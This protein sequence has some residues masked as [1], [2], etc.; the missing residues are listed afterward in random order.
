MT[1]PRCQPENRPQAK[2]SR[3]GSKCASHSGH[4]HVTQPRETVGVEQRR[5]AESP[6]SVPAGARRPTGASGPAIVG[7]VLQHGGVG[8]KMAPHVRAAPRGPD[9]VLD[10][11]TERRLAM[12]QRHLGVVVLLAALSMLVSVPATGQA[13][14]SEKEARDLG[15]EAYIYGYPLV[16]MEMT[17]AGDDQRGGS[18][19]RPRPDGPVR[20]P[21]R[22]P[23]RLVQRRH[24]AQRRH[25]LL[26][27]VPRRHEGAVRPVPAGRGGSLLP[28]ADALRLDRRVPGPGQAHDRHQAPDLRDHR[29]RLEGDASGRRQG[30]QVSDRNGLDPRPHL[31]H[32]HARGLQGGARAAG[33]VQAGAAVGLRQALHA[34][35]RARSIRAS[36]R[37]PRCASR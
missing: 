36:T 6:R 17:Q 11:Q 16:T 24:R 29:S 10:I 18:G 20:Q 5:G 13:A 7:E 33:P 34:A 3:R 9:P 4:S 15:V 1:C 32:R 19:G 21:A 37:R 14:L 27:G 22:V 23:E 12:L 28:D 31:L 26:V 2:F 35:G 30:A 8:G 25:A